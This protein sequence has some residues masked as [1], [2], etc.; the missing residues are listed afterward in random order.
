VDN[1][2]EGGQLLTSENA[3]LLC[4]EL[5]DPW[6]TRQRNTLRWVVTDQS[7]QHSGGQCRTNRFHDVP[8][9]HGRV[10]AT[11]QRPAQLVRVPAEQGF[12]V[13]HRDLPDFGAPPGAGP[14]PP[15]PHANACHS[16]R[17]RT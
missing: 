14:T 8:N 1:L 4:V 3:S 10:E 13:E 17:R 6:S 2:K 5:V 15:E 7:L 12:D 11:A 9:W 16:R